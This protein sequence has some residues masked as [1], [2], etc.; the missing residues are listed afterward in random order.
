MPR[1]TVFDVM[2]QKPPFYEEV[3]KEQYF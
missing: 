2:W 1:F 3:T